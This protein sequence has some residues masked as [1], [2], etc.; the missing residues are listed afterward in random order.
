MTSVHAARSA[1]RTHA[2]VEARH[3]DDAARA[4]RARQRE[5]HSRTE[6]SRS[7]DRP[8]EEHKGRHVDTTA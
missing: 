7:H 2:R 1:E 8:H 6:A 4:A 5:S 3:D